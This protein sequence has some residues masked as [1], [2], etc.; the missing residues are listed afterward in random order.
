MQSPDGDES[1]KQAAAFQ[2]LL[3][4]I[5]SSSA[6]GGP[7]NR[8]I[9]A[10]LDDR[11]P[12]QAWLAGDHD[13]VRQLASGWYG[14]SEAARQKATN[15]PATMA[16]L[17]HQLR[18]LDES[19]GRRRS[20]LGRHRSTPDQ[21]TAEPS[22]KDELRHWSKREHPS[23]EASLTVDAWVGSQ[24]NPGWK[25]PSVSIP[26]LS[27]GEYE[28]RVAEIPGS[29]GVSVFYRRPLEAKLIHH[30]VWVGQLTSIER[31]N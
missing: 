23:L 22:G 3:A 26:E 31:L 17:R 18:M 20:V 28:V 15:D 1:Q 9:Y 6:R 24:S 11:T 19:E 12:T 21:G 10:E 25:A 29:G 5:G 27:I 7:W 14:A 30:L 4:E 2:L 8:V 16:L 13:R